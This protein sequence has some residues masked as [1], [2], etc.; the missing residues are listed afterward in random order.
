MQEIDQFASPKARKLLV[1]NKCHL[2]DKKVVDYITAKV[3]I[4]EIIPP[5]SI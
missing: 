1:G 4:D 5:T 2:L 3:R